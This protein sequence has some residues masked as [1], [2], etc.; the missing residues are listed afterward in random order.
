MSEFKY[1]GLD[2]NC[3]MQLRQ[4]YHNRLGYADPKPTPESIS[5]VFRQQE[6]QLK[7]LKEFKEKA[8]TL[9]LYTDNYFDG[10]TTRAQIAGI[11][12]ETERR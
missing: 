4:E 7:N 1:A 3:I 11:V 10:K 12:E 9:L 8:I 6:Q 2:G 5:R